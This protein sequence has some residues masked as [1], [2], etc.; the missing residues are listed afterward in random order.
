M[1]VGFAIITT[2]AGLQSI[3]VID[4]KTLRKRQRKGKQLWRQ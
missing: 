3:H 1:R 4:E 2:E